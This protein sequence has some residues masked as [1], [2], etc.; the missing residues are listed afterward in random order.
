MA[1]AS[2]RARL[3]AR[4]SGDRREAAPS[5]PPSA[6]CA[7]PRPAEERFVLYA[8]RDGEL[9]ELA[10]APDP[11]GLGLAIVELHRDGQTND[12]R[13]RLYEEGMI[14]IRDSAAGEWIVLPFTRK[15]VLR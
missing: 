4:R 3:G 2:S 11:Q 14:G 8:Q 6:G 1:A 13:Y 12:H 7:A 9:R 5:N 15:E 10:C